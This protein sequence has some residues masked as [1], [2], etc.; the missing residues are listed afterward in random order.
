MSQA[1]PY[2]HFKDKRELMSAIAAAGFV[3]LRDRLRRAD[4][5][6]L[7]DLT[8]LGV[9]YLAFAKDNPG[10][11]QLM[12]GPAT[13]VDPANEELAQA[14]QEAFDVLAQIAAPEESD[15]KRDPGSVAAWALVHGLAM[16]TMHQKLPSARTEA[17]EEI[18][19]LLRPG[20]AAR[21]MNGR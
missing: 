7:G 9:A 2:A 21:L 8:Q 12:F 16:L 5:S 4:A 10:L 15:G 13:E 19:E 17:P 18:I 3:R 14:G 20:V 1:A 11:Y 6:G